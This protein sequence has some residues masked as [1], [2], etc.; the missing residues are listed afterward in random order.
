M[1]KGVLN[2]SR[3]FLVVRVTFKIYVCSPARSPSQQSS[4]LWDL[5]LEMMESNTPPQISLPD[6]AD[7][8]EVSSQRI[9]H[10]QRVAREAVKTRPEGNASATQGLRCAALTGTSNKSPG[11]LK[12]RGMM[13]PVQDPEAHD[14]L[15]DI[16][17]HASVS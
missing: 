13:Q 7:D 4:S 3:S 12:F 10:D 6:K 11:L 8:T 5:L 16:L 9:F 14:T 2:I 1:N 17:Q 15:I